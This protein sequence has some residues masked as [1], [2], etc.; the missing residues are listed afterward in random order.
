MLKKFSQFCT[1][2]TI[3]F[4][5]LVRRA[6]ILVVV[7]ALILMHNLYILVEMFYPVT[8]EPS[9]IWIYETVFRQAE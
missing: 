9:M 4:F 3:G 6:D 5:N 7:F 2:A 8:G 1:R